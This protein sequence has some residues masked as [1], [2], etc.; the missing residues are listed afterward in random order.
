[1]AEHLQLIRPSEAPPMPGGFIETETGRDILRTLRLVKQ[2]FGED[3]GLIA[4]APGVGKSEAV[5]CF[6]ELNPH[7]LMHRVVAGEGGIWNTAIA[8]CRLLE[9]GE[10]NGRKL[11]DCRRRIAEVIGPEVMLVFDEAQYLVQR[12][13]RGKDDWQ[14]FEWLRAMAEEG[15]FSVV[16]CGDLASC[17]VEKELPQLWRRMRRRIIVLRIPK[18]DVEAIAAKWGITYPDGVEVL[19]KVA[20]RGGFLGDVV[21]GCKHAR[22]LSGRK[23]PSMEDLLAALEDLKLLPKVVK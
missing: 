8:L 11:D 13:M 23:N 17:A 19:F 5:W 21:S 6:K 7:V 15:C 3:V 12:N 10:P 14:A 2:G 18:G 4:G 20:N 16:F 22:L 9:I 1:M